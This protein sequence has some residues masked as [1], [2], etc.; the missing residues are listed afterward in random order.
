MWD[1]GKAPRTRRVS[2]ANLEHECFEQES[3]ACSLVQISRAEHRRSS[4]SWGGAKA[5]GERS[6]P[7]ACA[8]SLQTAQCASMEA[9]NAAEARAFRLA[10]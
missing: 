10:E 6:E 2:A 3:T 9:A 4:K 7:E 5:Q 8:Y 1:F